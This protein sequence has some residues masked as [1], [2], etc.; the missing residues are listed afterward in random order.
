[1]D[2]GRYGEALVIASAVVFATAGLFA[3]LIHLDA[4][5]V[6]LWRGVVGGALILGCIAWRHRGTTA[7]EFRR[8]GR[9]GLIAAACSALAT[10][11]FINALQRTTVADVTLIH[12]AA[13]FV[14]AALGWA[15]TGRRESRVTLAAAAAAMAGVAVIVGASVAAGHLAGD[16]LALAMTV[17]VAA[18]M[19]VVRGSPERSMLPASCLSAFVSAALAAPVAAPFSPSAADAAWL[20][21]FGA[22]FGLGLLLLTVGTRRIAATRA[23][24]IGSLEIPLAPVA[25]WLAF[26]ELPSWRAALGGAIVAAAV[27]GDLLLGR[28]RGRV[29]R[30]AAPAASPAA[31]AAPRAAR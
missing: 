16:L 2:D 31:A 20:A 10:I 8:M 22:Q 25:V 24:L 11:C 19:V 1:M 26:A 6:V 27:L 13:P 3:R 30:P 29:S 14:T 23:A 12:A 18:M 28:P 7:A 21:L 17:L 4:W 5:T 9:H 15:W